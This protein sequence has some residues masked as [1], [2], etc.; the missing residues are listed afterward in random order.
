MR[1]TAYYICSTTLQ[2]K[3]NVLWRSN[4]TLLNCV[5]KRAVLHKSIGIWHTYISKK[6]PRADYTH[7]LS[8]FHADIENQLYPLISS[9]KL[10]RWTLVSPVIKLYQR[11]RIIP[12]FINWWFPSTYWQIAAAKSHSLEASSMHYV[13]IESQLFYLL[14]QKYK[15]GTNLYNSL[16]VQVCTGISFITSVRCLVGLGRNI[17][18]FGSI[19]FG[20]AHISR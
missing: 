2:P 12:W 6:T 17:T 8:L 15:K 7:T 4:Y 5:V 1:P 10:N 19:T 13:N 9:F 11:K 20:V 16:C 14:I 3:V 18:S